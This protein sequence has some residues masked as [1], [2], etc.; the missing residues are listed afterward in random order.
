MEACH[1]RASQARG[2]LSSRMSASF[3][4]GVFTL[5]LDF[6]LVWGSP[7]LPGDRPELERRARVTRRQV[8]EPLLRL[9]DEHRVVATWATVGNLFR[10]EAV[11]TR[12]VL[13]PDIVPPR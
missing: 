3:D 10:G 7:A 2:A 5:S 4:R 13:Y 6:E 8:F 11:R 9:L 12:G 1:T